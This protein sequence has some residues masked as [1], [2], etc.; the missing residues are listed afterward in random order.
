M[1]NRGLSLGPKIWI[2]G[3]KSKVSQDVRGGRYVL[4]RSGVS[5]YVFGK[6]VTAGVRL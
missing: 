1:Q 2:A 6:V 3:P 5:T 4:R